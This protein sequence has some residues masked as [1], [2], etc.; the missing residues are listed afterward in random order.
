MAIF[1]LTDYGQTAMTA[2]MAGETEITITSAKTSDSTKLTTDAY[3][4]FVNT[5]Q[6]VT[7]SG[8]A[9]KTDTGTALVTAVFTNSSVATAYQIKAVGLYATCAGSYR[10]S[11]PR[12]YGYC[13]LDNPDSMPLP[14][15]E[16]I[17]F[18][19]LINT[20]VSNTSAITIEMT[21][22]AYASASD[23]YELTNLV[24]TNEPQSIS[25]RCNNTV[26]NTEKTGYN[27]MQEISLQGITDKYWIDG[28]ISAGT[29]NGIW[30][31]ESL[32]DKIRLWFL[33]KPATSVFVTI[34]YFKTY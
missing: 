30:A 10:M 27:Y 3:P 12:L 8:I 17:S 20:K 19:Y 25:I 31:V 14:T 26:E 5:V 24:H 32:T 23:F 11:T 1:T 16:P 34:T 21:D 22:G 28:F 15:V 4:D 6:T 29:Y 33:T 18:T 2:A 7:P 13:I 9:L